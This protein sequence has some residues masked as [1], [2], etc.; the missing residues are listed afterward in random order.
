MKLRWIIIIL[1]VFMSITLAF[2]LKSMLYYK[3]HYDLLKKQQEHYVS[4]SKYLVGRSEQMMKSIDLEQT[5]LD[6]ARYE[7][8]GIIDDRTTSGYVKW[9]CNI[10]TCT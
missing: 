7:N 8:I 6:G 2:C 3:I 4:Q 1:F 10:A 9:L 5:K